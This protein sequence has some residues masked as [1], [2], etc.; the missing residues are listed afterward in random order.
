MI[1]ETPIFNNVYE[2]K[3]TLYSDIAIGSILCVGNIPGIKKCKYCITYKE[4]IKIYLPILKE[5][6]PIVS[7]V[8]CNRPNS[9]QL[10]LF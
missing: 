4:E 5:F 6:V 3:C 10:E 7:E 9:K 2:K 8:Y 1:I